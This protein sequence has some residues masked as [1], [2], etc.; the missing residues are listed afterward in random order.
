MS[1]NYKMEVDSPS[2][3][4]LEAINLRGPSAS[5]VASGGVTPTPNYATTLLTDPLATYLTSPTF[6]SCDHTSYSVSNATVVL[7]PG[8]Y[9]K[10]LNIS[11]NSTETLNPGLYIITGG[12]T[13]ASSTVTGSGVTLFFTQ[14]G[15]GGFGQFLLN[16]STVYLSAPASSSGGS[17]PAITVFADRSWTPTAAQDFR[18]YFSTMQGDGI[19]YMPGAGLYLWNAGTVTGSNYFGIVADNLYLEG[20]DLNPRGD[21]SYVST[22]NPFRRQGAIVQ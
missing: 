10:G 20:T 18:L 6:S 16:F 3:A 7:N 2:H 1:V 19:W 13:W 21:Y 15:G 4:N 5:L 14:G 9:C 12:A 17:I 22:G 8:T 11:N